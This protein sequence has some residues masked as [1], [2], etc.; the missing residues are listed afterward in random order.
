MMLSIIVPAYNVE[1]YLDRCIASIIIQQLKDYEI[2]IINDGSTDQTLKIA[3]LLEKKYSEIT[4]ISQCNAG[5][6]AVR[7]KGIKIAKGKYILFLDSDD[8]YNPNCVKFLL[9]QMEEFNLDVLQFGYEINKTG[10]VREAFLPNSVELFNSKKFIER[11]FFTPY[12]VT[13]IINTNFLIRENIYFVEGKFMEDDYFSTELFLKASRIGRTDLCVY[14]YYRNANSITR[15]R[16]LSHECKIIED[17]FFSITQ[18]F[19]LYKYAKR[20]EYSENALANLQER[21]EAIV[22]FTLIRMLRAGIS[23]DKIID[24]L[25]AIGFNKFEIFPRNYYGSHLRINICKL[26][27]YLFNHKFVI[28]IFSKLKLFTY[29]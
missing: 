16:N 11:C 10:N 19:Q 12:A 21:R 28:R 13:K 7:N 17:L 9:E 29:V 24:K 27:K 2:V 1:E 4:V 6:S 3:Q 8:F 23:F 5:L 15:T 22:F 25:D 18:H 14:N 26:L 20:K